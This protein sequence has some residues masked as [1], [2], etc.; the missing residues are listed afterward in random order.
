M[1]FVRDNPFGSDHFASTCLFSV[2]HIEYFHLIFVFL[3]FSLGLIDQSYQDTSFL[4]VVSHHFLAFLVKA[5]FHH[6]V[7]VLARTRIPALVPLVLGMDPMLIPVSSPLGAARTDD[8]GTQLTGTEH[9]CV[10]V[11]EMFSSSH[12]S[13]RRLSLIFAGL[14]VSKSSHGHT[15]MLTIS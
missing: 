13:R 15:A 1:S 9:C 14:P 10:T 12:P 2:D 4:N 3:L 7:D 5:V 8:S 11:S 6:P